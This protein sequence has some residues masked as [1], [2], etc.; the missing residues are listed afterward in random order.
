MTLEQECWLL[1]QYILDQETHPFPKQF[2]K[3]W[4][5]LQR[6]H[7]KHMLPALAHVDAHIIQVFC[8]TFAFN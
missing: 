1:D 5:R 4:N 7:E 6:R 3:Q 8:I 2:I